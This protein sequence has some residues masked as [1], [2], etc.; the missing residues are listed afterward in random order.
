LTRA[1]TGPL[2]YVLFVVQGCAVTPLTNKIGPGEDAFVIV[3]G[4]GGDGST[5]LF[6]APATGGAFHQLTFNRLVE[7][8][9]TLAPNGKSVALIRRRDSLDSGPTELVVLDLMTMAEASAALPPGT[10]P[11]RIG[12]SR[13]GGAI[14]VGG[15]AAYA[16]PSPPRRI[17]L[18]RVP[19]D[20]AA[21]A[22]SLTRPLLGDPVFAIVRECGDGAPCVAVGEQTTSLGT[23]ARDPFRWGTNAVAYVRQGAIEIRPLGGGRA[24]RPTWTNAPAD[25]RQPTHHPGK[26]AESG[27]QRAESREQ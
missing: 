24:R 14:Y 4:E 21:L 18:E 27:E 20:S 7:S 6:A 10:R 23:D 2:L 5:D 25:L 8:L 16:T 22:D 26:S 9:P 3:V 13:D 15:S 17:A 1:P 12:W 11:E 19:A